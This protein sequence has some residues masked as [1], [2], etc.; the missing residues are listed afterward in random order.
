MPGTF[1]GTAEAERRIAEEAARRTGRLDLRNLGL[2][3]LPEALFRLTHLRALDL[4]AS[5]RRDDPH[6]PNRVGRRGASAVGADAA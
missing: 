5:L 1:D 2:P 4:G 3:A 6:Q